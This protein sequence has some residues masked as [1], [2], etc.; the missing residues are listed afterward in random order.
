MVTDD[1]IN[2]NGT[3]DIDKLERAIDLKQ[4]MAGLQLVVQVKRFTEAGATSLVRDKR[5]KEVRL[6]LGYACLQT[7]G[8]T[9]DRNKYTDPEKWATFRTLYYRLVSEGMD[10]L[11]ADDRI[12]LDAEM[13]TLREYVIRHASVTCVTTSN[14]AAGI[15][16]EN[17]VVD[18]VILDE[19]NTASLPQMIILTSHYEPQHLLLVGDT[20]QLKPVVAGPTP[21]TGFIPELEVSA[22][23]YFARPH[24]PVAEI[25]VQRRSRTGIMDIPTIRY[26][27]DNKV[28]YLPAADDDAI[29]QYTSHLIQLID[30][31]IP[32]NKA[33]S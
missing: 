18:L 6:G 33:E 11:S 5:V 1:C 4:G 22:M 16:S 19:A 17:L 25:Y 13:K 12:A 3:L 32:N 10:N 27:H 15:Y 31:M 21:F 8:L 28:H 2:N 29:H 30:E 23:S 7:A 26:Y 9:E 20:R 24:W 14:A